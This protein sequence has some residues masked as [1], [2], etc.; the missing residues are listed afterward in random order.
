[1]SRRRRPH[2]APALRLASCASLLWL[3][4]CSTGRY[5]WIDDYVEPPAPEDTTYMVRPF[6]VLNVMVW[7]QA[8]LT[9]RV[10]VRADGKV[11][12]PLLDDVDAAGLTPSA[13]AKKI[14]E[15]LRGLV[16]NAV[17]TV[18]VEESTPLMVAVLGEVKDPG[19]KQLEPG[20]GLLQALAMGGGF[21][22][23]ARDDLLFVLR[24]PP[25]GQEGVPTRI[26]FTYRALIR[27]E[28]RAAAFR[29]R[30]RD[31]VVVE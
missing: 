23:Y 26:R 7:N 27:T 24:P 16:N 20:S 1:M 30:P 2:L 3:A 12:V 5:V 15:Q 14:Q 19:M 17:V 13:L 11:S 31:V 21:T 4:A 9:N 18:S 28:G 29:L 8:A 25:P 22:D 6:D 10:R